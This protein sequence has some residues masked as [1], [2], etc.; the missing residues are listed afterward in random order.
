MSRECQ[1]AWAGPILRGVVATPDLAG[2]VAGYRDG[3]GWRLRRRGR[4]APA[5]A[6]A[7]SA[8][9]LAGAEYAVLGPASRI[10]GDLQ[11]VAVPPTPVPQPLR[12]Y[13]WAALELLVA[14]L[15]ATLAGLA[16]APGGL[17]AAPGGPAGRFTVLGRP[18]AL[19]G[20]AA[21][22][23]AAQLAGPAGEVIYLTEVR[24]PV[25]PFA[26][27]VASPGPG[28]D[29]VFVAVL[30]ARD[31]D[32]TRAWWERRFPVRRCTD[33]PA[34]IGVLNR[35]HGRSP[36]ATTRISSLQ[37]AGRSVLEID[38]YPATAGPRPVASGGSL[39]PG[40]ALIAIGVPDPGTDRTNGGFMVAR[41]PDAALVELVPAPRPIDLV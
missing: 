26:L 28:A 15:D 8:P 38:Q 3:L 5:T 41:G 6:R 30:A 10:G 33:R 31:L 29:G 37:L 20:P 16:A 36:A 40:I 2:S 22:L 35:A 11:L 13:G 12:H 7:W 17:A 14:D 9:A 34:T 27:P 32:A 39:P 25:P 18:A 4:L 23:R 24:R 19:S 1:P 21:P